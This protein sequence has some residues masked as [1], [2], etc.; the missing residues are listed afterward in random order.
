MSCKEFHC[1]RITEGNL[2]VLFAR[3]T[4]AWNWC[5]KIDKKRF[6]PIFKLAGFHGFDGDFR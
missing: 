4:S 5:H 1:G 2:L 6:Y 3:L